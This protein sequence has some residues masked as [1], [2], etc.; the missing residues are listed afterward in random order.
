M[1]TLQTL[2]SPEQLLT[3]GLIEGGDLQAITEVAKHFSIGISAQI[4]GLIQKDDAN[5]PIAAQFVPS[6]R[7]LSL[8]AEELQDPI[9][10]ET[11][12]PL[13]GIVHRYPDRVLL[14]LTSAC[15]V[16]CRFCFRRETVGKGS[17]AL[18]EAHLDRALRYIESTPQVWEVILSGGDPLILSPRRLGGIMQRLGAIEHV[19]VIRFHTRVPVVRPEIVDAALIAALKIDKAV[20]VILHTN[21]VRELSVEAR[22]ACARLIDAGFPMLSQT[23]LLKGVN[24]D[25]ATLTTLFRALVALRVKPY[26]LHHG[27]LARGTAH[28][29]TSI[30]QG[31]DIMRELRATVSGLCQPAYVLDVPG[32]YGKVPVGP[33]H[34]H[35]SEDGRLEVTDMRGGRHAYPA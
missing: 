11:H 6:P 19:G 28:F 10:D 34:V 35:R 22:G 17:G 2:R 15:P 14:K 29:R 9:G 25:A 8:A 21:H 27:D 18:D 13:A 5:D 30:D 26:Y 7:E 12:S 16:Y 1:K 32:G 23:V 20:Y 24:A 33:N 4:H 31:Q 3:A